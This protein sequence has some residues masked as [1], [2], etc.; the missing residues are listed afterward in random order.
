MLSTPTPA[1]A[2]YAQPLAGMDHVCGHLGRA[3]HQKGI[4]LAN[5]VDQLF[6][7]LPRDHVY[8]QI[9]GCLEGGKARI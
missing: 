8:D 4:V 9:G 2:N 3:A 1:R 7:R 6:L 5:H